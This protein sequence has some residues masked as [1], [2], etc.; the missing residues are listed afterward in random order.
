MCSATA[1][2]DIGYMYE[3][4]KGVKTNNEQAF[5][6]YERAAKQGHSDAQTSLGHMY[7]R[8]SSVPQDYNQAVYWYQQAARQ[9]NSRAQRNLMV[10]Y[11]KLGGDSL[12]QARIWHYVLAK[13]DSPTADPELRATAE[14]VLSSSLENVLPS[15]R[16][17][18]FR[19]GQELVNQ[20]KS[21]AQ[22]YEKRQSEISEDMLKTSMYGD[23]TYLIQLL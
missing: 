10:V 7:S 11:E 9:G 12:K 14:K 8:G 2:F 15:K 17:E 19:E 16:E 6:W 5:K 1:Q 22:E 23:P 4:G 13:S 18:I 3:N 20:V 21:H